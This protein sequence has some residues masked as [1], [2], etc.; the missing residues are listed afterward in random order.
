MHLSLPAAARLLAWK[1]VMGLTRGS[2]NDVLHLA[3]QLH[4]VL[5]PDGSMHRQLHCWQE[6]ALRIALHIIPHD[7]LMASA[8]DHM[9][10]HATRTIVC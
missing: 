9:L 2:Y 6:C 4:A 10:L 1:G 7:A 3:I 5:Q 8:M